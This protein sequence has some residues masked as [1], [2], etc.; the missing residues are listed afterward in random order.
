[1]GR[2]TIIS[3]TGA[4]LYVIKPLYD[5][6]LITSQIA[7]LT[8]KIVIFDS[9]ITTIEAERDIIIDEYDDKDDE[10]N[11]AID[12]Y[13]ADKTAENL[14]AISALTS[15]LGEITGR[16]RNKTR[17][18]G[19]EKL[20]KSSA[21]KRKTKLE[22]IV[23][24]VANRSAWNV[25]Y[26]EGLTGEVNTIE[27]NGEAGEILIGNFLD[28]SKL[29]EIF[30]QTV[31][32]SLYNFS[33][34]PYWQKWNPTHRVGTI[35]ALSGNLATV[36]LDAA[37]SHYQ[38]LNINQASTLYNVPISYMSC[39]ETAFDVGD[40]VV[41]G[42]TSQDWANPVIIG[43]KD[44]PVQCPSTSVSAFCVNDTYALQKWDVY[45]VGGSSPSISFTNASLNAKCGQAN[46]ENSLTN[47]VS[48]Q[49]RV[50]THDY[51][52]PTN[53][54][55]SL[56]D[57]SYSG[58]YTL[59]L[60]WDSP[61]VYSNDEDYNKNF[62]A[63]AFDDVDG[64]SPSISASGAGI[65]SETVPSI[66]I[67]NEWDYLNFEKYYFI[68]LNKWISIDNYTGGAIQIVIF[69]KTQFAGTSFRTGARYNFKYFL[70]V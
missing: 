24:D 58:G 52:Q 62:Y 36:S 14:A 34:F 51:V 37:T 15:E 8:A 54:Y 53:I 32:G 69:Q 55:K 9:N 46:S 70:G 33:L 47:F 65:L 31:A 28:P 6:D 26:V 49:F 12:A 50:E 57:L 63:I 7:S 38:G 20:K 45:D 44:N 17:E 43:F 27:I 1:M 10:L 39:N 2:A 19:F 5:N 41:L 56:Y 66:W 67:G 42:F 21:E 29:I 4:G 35:T 13:N 25:A 3:E 68:D 30:G 18:L 60:Q 23:S 61:F 11:A 40:E 64:L 22:N 16:L 59:K 48:G